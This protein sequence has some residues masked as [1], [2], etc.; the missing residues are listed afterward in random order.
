MIQVLH[1]VAELN[2]VFLCP[3]KYLPDAGR[4]DFL[5]ALL[6]HEHANQEPVF[7]ETY[8]VE[9]APR[10]TRYVRVRAA[11]RRICPDW[12]IGVGGPAW[13]FADELVVE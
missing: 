3:V 12:H 1:H 2:L 5:V 9:F 6:E 8:A 11:S 13:I 4:N 10:A 7:T